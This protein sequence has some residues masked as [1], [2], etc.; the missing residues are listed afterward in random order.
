[1]RDVIPLS[2]KE[3]LAVSSSRDEECL[4][5]KMVVIPTYP[6]KVLWESIKGKLVD[7]FVGGNGEFLI[8]YEY[9]LLKRSI[10]SLT[11]AKTPSK[12]PEK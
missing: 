6:L 2:L 8:A 4:R 10:G 3:E 11:I 5:Q 7:A 9:A 1:M 12:S